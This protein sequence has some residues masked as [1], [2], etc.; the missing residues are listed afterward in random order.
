MMTRCVSL[1][2]LALAAASGIG[3]TAIHAQAPPRLNAP[4]YY[5]AEFEL[6]DPRASGPTAQA[7]PRPLSR[8]AGDSSSEAARSLRSKA[9]APR[10]DLW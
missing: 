3:A 9:N 10:E 2:G 5:I 8:S 7:L 6:T 1:A 4:A